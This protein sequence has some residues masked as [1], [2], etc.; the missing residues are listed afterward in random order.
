M[1]CGVLRGSFTNTRN[2]KAVQDDT[3]RTSLYLETPLSHTER[4]MKFLAESV[5]E[6]LLAYYPIFLFPSHSS[7]EQDFRDVIACR[8]LAKGNTAAT[9][10]HAVDVLC[11]EVVV[12]LR[13]SL[14]HLRP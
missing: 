10:H 7:L 5:S 12:V 14:H 11:E 8:P 9:L 13:I 1:I 3:N 2:L 6:T 4:P